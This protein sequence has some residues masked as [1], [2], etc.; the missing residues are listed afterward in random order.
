MVSEVKPET[1][2]FIFGKKERCEIDKWLS[3]Y[4]KNGKKSALVCALFQAQKQ[5][6]G[7][8]SNQVIKE[9]ADYLK[10]SNVEVLEVATFYDMFNLTP[11]G[12]HKISVCTN[13]SCML[14]G[15]GKIINAI[16]EKLGISIGETTS[17]GMFTLKECECLA[18]CAGAPVC[19]VDDKEYHENLDEKKIQSVIDD[20]ISK[21]KEKNEQ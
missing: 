11:I 19:Q 18:A 1:R 7:W 13:V 6:G 21:E 16:E 4:P 2:K 5:N 15:S 3:K 14:R 12:K 8:I 20:I 9:V 10:I 17:D